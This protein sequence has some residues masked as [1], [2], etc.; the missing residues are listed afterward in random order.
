MKY[1]TYM[2]AEY[3]IVQDERGYAPQHNTDLGWQS[4]KQ[5]QSTIQQARDIIQLHMT[6][7]R[8]PHAL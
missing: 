3:R 5:P 4:I 7:A 8:D 1:D 6:N 2:L